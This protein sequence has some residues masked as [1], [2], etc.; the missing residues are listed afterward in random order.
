MNN[1]SPD[2][3]AENVKRALCCPELEKIAENGRKLVEKKFC[4]EYVVE[5]WNEI[6][7]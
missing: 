6:F 7:K 3:I 4:Y 1:N 5:R 2:C